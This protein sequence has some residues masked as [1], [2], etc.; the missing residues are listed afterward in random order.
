LPLPGSQNPFLRRRPT[1][2]DNPD[3]RALPT[4]FGG[5]EVKF[6]GRHVRSHQTGMES[7]V[8]AGWEGER[9]ECCF[10]EVGRRTRPTVCFA[11]VE[12]VDRIIYIFQR[13]NVERKTRTFSVFTQAA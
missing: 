10:V 3:H 1:P 13:F 4:F 2:E 8:E 6:L 5:D 9:D 11:N 7:G 12:S